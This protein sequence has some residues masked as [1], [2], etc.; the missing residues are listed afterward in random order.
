MDVGNVKIE[1]V[2]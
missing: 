1:T 2:D